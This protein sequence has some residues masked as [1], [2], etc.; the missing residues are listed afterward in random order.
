M[1]AAR[2]QALE[3]GAYL[4][5]PSKPCKKGHLERYS[6]TGICRKCQ[7]ELDAVG[8]RKAARKAYDITHSEDQKERAKKYE[9][10]EKGRRRKLLSN[11]KTRAKKFSVPFDLHIEDII[12]PECCPALGIKLS[13]GVKSPTGASPSLDRLIPELGYVRGNISIISHRANSI[14]NDATATE[15]RRVADW[16]DSCKGESPWM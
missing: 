3:I 6:S 4:Y 7:S 15:L 8:T 11:A 16:I 10:S 2:A 5:A 9:R 12:I 13:H 1:D 14:K